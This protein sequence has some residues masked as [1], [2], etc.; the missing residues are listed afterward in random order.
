[1][2]YEYEAKPI[3]L[4]AYTADLGVPVFTPSLEPGLYLGPESVRSG[5]RLGGPLCRVYIY[6][7]KTL[8]ITVILSKA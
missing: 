6:I 1:M 7:H 5:P 3:R 8:P 4:I 2:R